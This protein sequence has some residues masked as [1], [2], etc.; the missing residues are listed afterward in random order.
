MSWIF[1]S[2]RRAG[3][4]L[5][6]RA[7]NSDDGVAPRDS[8][9]RSLLYSR[10]NFKMTPCVSGQAAMVEPTTSGLFSILYFSG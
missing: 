5:A 2:R 8:W 10:M 6:L 1:W 9:G 3:G 4:T 7:A